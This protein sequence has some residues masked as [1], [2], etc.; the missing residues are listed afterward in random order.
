M[1]WGINLLAQLQHNKVKVTE[2]RF[3]MPRFCSSEREK[4]DTGFICALIK[5][6][7]CFILLF[8]FFLQ[9]GLYLLISYTN[10]WHQPPH[11][12]TPLCIY[13]VHRSRCVCC[14]SLRRCCRHKGWRKRMKRGKRKIYFRKVRRRREIWM[15]LLQEEGRRFA[16]AVAKQDAIH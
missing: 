11:K 9:F 12:K 8:F 14:A 16:L 5:P 2:E 6:G 7:M 1:I 15:Q 13:L 3:F 10:L 4:T